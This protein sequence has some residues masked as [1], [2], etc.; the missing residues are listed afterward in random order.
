MYQD[1]S[2]NHFN[3]QFRISIQNEHYLNGSVYTY[4]MS[5]PKFLLI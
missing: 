4:I 3:V 5:T 2:L 1:E